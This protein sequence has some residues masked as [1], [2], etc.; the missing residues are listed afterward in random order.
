MLIYWLTLL[1]LLSVVVVA[2]V[3]VVV[4]VVVLVVLMVVRSFRQVVLSV[5]ICCLKSYWILDIWISN[6]HLGEKKLGETD[7]KFNVLNVAFRVNLE[8]I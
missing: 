6:P 7:H 5:Y 2:V 8:L 4:V 3:A 1:L